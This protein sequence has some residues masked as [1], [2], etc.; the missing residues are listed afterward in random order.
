MTAA[1][2]ASALTSSCD[3]AR[4][5]LLHWFFDTALPTWFA[6][7]ID[8]AQGGFHEQLTADAAPHDEPRRT[9]VA[10]RQIYVFT[11]AHRLGWRGDDALKAV[12]HGLDF[13]LG[14]LRQPDGLFASSVDTRGQVINPRFDLYEQ[15]FALFAMAHVHALGPCI[16]ADLRAQLQGHAHALMDALQARYKHP[17]CGFEESHP[18]SAPLKSDPHMHMLE[19]TLAWEAQ[20]EAGSR[21]HHLSDEL[22]HLALQHLIDPVS[23]AL[24]ELFDQGWRPLQP[25]MAAR[26]VQPGHQFEWG[27][28]LLRWGHA[29]QHAQALSAGRRLIAIG[30]Q[31]GVC[32][33]RQVAVNQLD[34]HFQVT[35]AQAKLW[36]QTERVKAL[37]VAGLLARDAQDKAA[38]Q[39]DTVRAIH[40][41]SAYLRHPCPGL[42]HEVMLADGQFQPQPALCRASSFY[43]VVCAIDTVMSDTVST[44][45]EPDRQIG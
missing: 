33:A 36:P 18:P 13:L 31:H 16:S 22:A 11:A 38:W 24:Y 30:R 12:H 42:W 1:S 19:A 43:H 40:S 2:T 9:R 6:R 5:G 29:R 37:H 25:A 39:A 17:A 34:G 26:A 14:R 35:D 15:A 21:W 27:W 8:W 10:A 44:P 7:G 32:G 45:Y 41:L 23:G 20:H 3:E 28:L 4:D